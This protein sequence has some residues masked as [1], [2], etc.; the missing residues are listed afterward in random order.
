MNHKEKNHGLSML[1]MCL[2]PLM[3]IVLVSILGIDL[4]PIG[5]LLPYAM[6]LIC[7]L[8]HVGIMLFVFKNKKGNKYI[9]SI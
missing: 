3:A 1:L 4:G 5:R 8:M 7:P 9:F 2:I 6:L